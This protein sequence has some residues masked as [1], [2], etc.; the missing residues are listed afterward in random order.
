M[1]AGSRA[2]CGGL[3][4]R[5]MPVIL[6]GADEMSKSTFGRRCGNMQWQCR[7]VV[8]T[9]ELAGLWTLAAREPVALVCVR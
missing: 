8:Q 1:C 9:D 4:L 3:W 7:R 5:Y 2:G 6:K